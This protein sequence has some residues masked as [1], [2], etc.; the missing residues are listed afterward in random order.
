MG[1][2]QHLH[3]ELVSL[4]MENDVMHDNTG[5]EIVINVSTNVNKMGLRKDLLIGNA[6]IGATEKKQ[7]S[8]QERVGEMTKKMSRSAP[9]VYGWVDRPKGYL[10]TSDS[11]NELVM[12][13][14]VMLP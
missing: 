1:K 10:K 12:N 3:I 7:L 13:F 9:T 4:V 2:N 11:F 14:G 6:S 8:R 5:E